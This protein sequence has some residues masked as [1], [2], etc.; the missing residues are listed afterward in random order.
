MRRMMPSR[1]YMKMQKPNFI[2]STTILV[3]EHKGTVALRIARFEVNTSDLDDA[4]CCI[5]RSSMILRSLWV[6]KPMAI[7]LK[8]RASKPVVSYPYWALKVDLS[9][10]S[11]CPAAERRRMYFRILIISQVSPTI[12]QT[13]ITMNVTLSIFVE[14]IVLK[15]AL[16]S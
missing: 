4:Y 16:I 5:L 13:R 15:L 8:N 14:R 1:L 7:G 2:N 10:G 11:G 3:E 12:I 6:S 9:R